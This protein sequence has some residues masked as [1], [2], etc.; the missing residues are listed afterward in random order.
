MFSADEFALLL[1]ETSSEGGNVL[2]KGALDAVW[3]LD[4]RI[5]ELEVNA[6]LVK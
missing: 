1:F 5:L 2:T 6:T 3:E 4:E